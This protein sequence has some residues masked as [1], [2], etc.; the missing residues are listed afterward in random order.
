MTNDEFKSS[1]ERLIGPLD[2][3]VF[4]PANA[5]RG[6]LPGVGMGRG[7]ISL[8]LLFRGPDPI[9]ARYTALARVVRFWNREAA[10][11]S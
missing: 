2:Y 3:V 6:I 10:P 4:T 7:G 11:T 5:S 9:S 8:G 1:I